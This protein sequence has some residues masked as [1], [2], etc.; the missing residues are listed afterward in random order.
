[1]F[2]LETVLKNGHTYR[3]VEVSGLE[4]S[5]EAEPCRF[6]ARWA[7]GSLGVGSNLHHFRGL[8]KQE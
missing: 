3:V 8:G 6:G 5:A 2:R 4:P 7:S 1:M